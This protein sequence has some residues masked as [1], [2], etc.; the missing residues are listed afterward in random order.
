MPKIH[1]DSYTLIAQTQIALIQ[2]RL[3]QKEKKKQKILVRFSN[4]GEKNKKKYKNRMAK[5]QIC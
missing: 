4:D 5:T 2:K 3:A 1:S